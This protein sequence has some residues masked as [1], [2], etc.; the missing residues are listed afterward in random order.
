M[1]F[2]SMSNVTSICGM[3]RGAGGMPVSWNLPS[4][5]LPAAIS[6]SPWRTWT[7]TCVWLS[8][9]VENVSDR[10][11]G[12]VVL[13]SMS[14]VI[15]PP[16]VSMPR[17][18]GVTSSRSTSLTSPARTPAWIAA[19]TATTSSGFTPLCGSLPVSSLTFSWT[20]GLR[21]MPPTMTTWSTLVS[22]SASACLTGATTRSSRS[23][24]S[25]LSF[26]RE[27]FISRW[28]G[29]PSTAVMNGRLICVSCVVESSILA[30]SAAS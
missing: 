13:R 3:P 12:I 8:S 29:W 19:P 23:P 7:S 9:A 5:L 18:S 21:V 16:L 17:V 22:A 6:R 26:A 10:L 28:R 1:P 4:D 27:S 11:V 2:A 15:T 20:A 30:F 14:L 24:V 25:S